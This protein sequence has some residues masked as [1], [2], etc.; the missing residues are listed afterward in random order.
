MPSKSTPRAT[1]TSPGLAIKRV[2]LDSLHVDPANA[3][4]HPETNLDAIKVSLARF[5]QA[6]ARVW[7]AEET[8][9]ARSAGSSARCLGSRAPRRASRAAPRD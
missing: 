1:R 3:R 5:G 2:P 6:D 9:S 8:R 4:L 7:E